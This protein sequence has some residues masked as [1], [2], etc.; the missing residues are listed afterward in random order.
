MKPTA[1][2]S[3]SAKIKTLLA[4]CRAGVLSTHALEPAGYPFGT[5]VP[6]SLDEAGRP[7]LLLSALA[8]H[9]RNLLADPRASLAVCDPSPEADPAS[10]ER[11]T[12]LAD[13]V[14][15]S[16]RASAAAS[17]YR[18]FPDSRSYGESLDFTFFRLDPVRIRY[19]G[20][21]GD[22]R[23]IAGADYR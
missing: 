12:Y 18:R 23:W 19:I 13:A 21:F 1:V 10:A 11:L 7:L 22:A 17:Y 9:T 2:E 20:G 6:Y 14:K 15:V 5:T 8:Q 16:D 3:P 4:A